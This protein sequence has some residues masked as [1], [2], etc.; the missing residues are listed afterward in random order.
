MKTVPV[1]FDGVQVGE[2]KVDE[3]KDDLILEYVIY[4]EASKYFQNLGPFS[5]SEGFAIK[6]HKTKEQ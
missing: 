2:A 6:P 4:P 1:T 3:T 5:I